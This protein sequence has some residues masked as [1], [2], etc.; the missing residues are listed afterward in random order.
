MAMAMILVGDMCEALW[1]GGAKWFLGR[2]ASANMDGTFN[3]QYDDGDSELM[4]PPHRIHVLGKLQPF[5]VAP[6][7]RVRAR[8][9]GG[10]YYSGTIRSMNM[11]GTYFVVFDD[12]DVEPGALLQNLEL[13]RPAALFIFN[14]GD[15]CE[16]LWKGGNVWFHGRIAG[17]NMDGTFAIAYDDG[18]QEPAVPRDRIRLVMQ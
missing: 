2:V 3:I 11:D 14:I 16:A 15:A 18:D 12:G 5:Q 13:A 4:V 9:K 7:V 8:W 6:G 1:K 10:N 17:A